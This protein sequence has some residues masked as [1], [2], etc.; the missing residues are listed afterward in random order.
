MDDLY[1]IQME[2]GPVKIG[3]SANVPSRLSSI[4]CASPYKV[5][6]L[7]VL[8]GCGD[9]EAE[10]HQLLWRHRMRGEWFKWT[11]LVGD[12]VETALAGG[13][14]R[15]LAPPAETQDDDD[16]WAGSPLFAVDAA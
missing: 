13:D 3:R 7:G 16:W 6:L 5:R 14:W 1:F 12:V 2:D 15:A 11:N 10:F 8:V 9:Q 4:Q